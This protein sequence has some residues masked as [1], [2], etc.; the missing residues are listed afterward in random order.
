MVG[1]TTGAMAVLKI[2]PLLSP[3]FL[4]GTRVLMDAALA[5]FAKI[6]V[7]LD[8]DTASSFSILLSDAMFPFPFPLIEVESY[9]ARVLSSSS[10]QSKITEMSPS[11]SKQ[12]KEWST[13]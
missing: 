4:T 5:S 12:A 10:N 7:L 2:S 8:N 6:L 13:S 11:E 3:G 1:A 9:S